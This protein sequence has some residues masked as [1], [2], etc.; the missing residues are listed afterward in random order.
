[1]SYTAAALIDVT[2]FD[3]AAFP[4][5][6]YRRVLGGVVSG[7]TGVATACA[8]VVAVAVAAIWIIGIALSA[9]PNTHANV[10]MGLQT[11]AL[12]KPYRT[13]AG[14]ADF[15]NL[16]RTTIH[17]AAVVNGTFKDKRAR[18][19]ME[20]TAAAR[21]TP[22]LRKPLVAGAAN[23]PP[24]PL[25]L[26]YAAQD[27]GKLET[28][29]L[30][31]L[32]QLAELTPAAAPIFT[33]ARMAAHA[34]KRTQQLAKGLPLPRPHPLSHPPS[35][36]KREIANRPAPPMRPRLA[37]SAPPPPAPL[38]QKQLAP[39][40]AQNNLISL[41]GPGSR[42]A[43]YDI[44]AHTVYLPNGG[45]LEAHS[46]LG[47]KRDDPRYVSVKNHGPTPPNVY[48]LA[49]RK[50]LF[51]GVR[52]IRLNP[53]GKGNMYG[54]DGMLAHTYMLGPTGQSFGCVSFKNYQ[55]F[56]SAFLNG[57]V[58]RLVVVARLQ[59]APPRIADRR[60]ART[61]RYAFNIR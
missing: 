15:P 48:D 26:L 36:Q 60:R 2:P 27:E 24:Q 52:A 20:A 39:Q 16:V 45:R 56:L 55:A 50:Q 12:V 11:I 37:T 47:D 31:S 10:S 33:P 19:T 30:A 61:Y 14:V 43:V 29:P 58:D 25:H 13:L 46:G 18:A 3:N 59:T 21:A 41:T 49:L 17:S 5:V 28:A 23:G 34:P 32:T 35:Q 22:H 51:H 53:V 7:L 1:M 6:D 54:R 9:N 40:Q 42:T 38:I 57:K 44:S 4:P 8:I